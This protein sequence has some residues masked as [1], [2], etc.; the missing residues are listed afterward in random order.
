M[1]KN[2]VN[3]NEILAT[4]R[5]AVMSER[6][7]RRVVELS[8]GFYESI[9]EAFAFMKERKDELS[10]KG[11]IDEYMETIVLEDRL[12]KEFSYFMQV[13]MSKL[14]EYSVYGNGSE[15]NLAGPEL[16]WFKEANQLYEKAISK[17][18]GNS[19]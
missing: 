4:L 18:E 11:K 6:R 7:Q 1:Q 10:S 13:R 2:T 16:F 15:F 19:Q 17:I 9:T 8:S 5:G 3:I 14:L 12:K